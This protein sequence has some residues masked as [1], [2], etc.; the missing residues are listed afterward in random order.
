[1]LVHYYNASSGG[2]MNCSIPEKKPHA[3]VRQVA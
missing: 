2:G 3:Y 1:M